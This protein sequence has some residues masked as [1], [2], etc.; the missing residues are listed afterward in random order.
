[1]EDLD[2][3]PRCERVRKRTGAIRR[4]VVDDDEFASIPAAA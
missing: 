2:A 4:V 3:V 1:M